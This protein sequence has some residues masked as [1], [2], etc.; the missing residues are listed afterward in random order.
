VIDVLVEGGLTVRLA[1]ELAET[2]GRTVE[3]AALVLAAWEKAGC[4]P[5]PGDIAALDVLGVGDGY[6]PSAAVVEG[7][8]RATARFGV[9]PTRTQIAVLVG[10]AGTRAEAL[11]L[12]EQGVLTATDALTTLTGVVLWDTRP[13]TAHPD[14]AQTE[15]AGTDTDTDT[16]TRRAAHG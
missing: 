16:D 1:E 12:I 13:P 14:A 2:T 10:L 7:L 15:P 5:G 9:R 8:Q 11:R 3:R 4:R 6:E